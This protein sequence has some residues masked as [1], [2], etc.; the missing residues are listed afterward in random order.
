MYLSN[1]ASLNTNWWSCMKKFINVKQILDI[2]ANKFDNIFIF[3]Y[4]VF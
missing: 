2:Y 3:I 4:V 1:M